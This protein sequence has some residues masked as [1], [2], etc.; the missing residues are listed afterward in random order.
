MQIQIHFCIS[1][2]DLGAFCSLMAFDGILFTQELHPRVTT[3][4][5]GSA[6]TI[7]MYANG[8]LKSH[9]LLFLSYFKQH[10]PETA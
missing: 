4:P 5:T 3:Q 2:L 10:K 1:V 6:I 9:F 8:C 7:E